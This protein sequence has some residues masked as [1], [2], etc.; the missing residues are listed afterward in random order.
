[1]DITHADALA[2]FVD[3]NS[4]VRRS[5]DL[6]RKDFRCPHADCTYGFSWTLEEPRDRDEWLWLRN[7]RN[8]EINK[9]LVTHIN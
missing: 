3:S 7:R 4:T 9:H 6:D 2:S 5:G 8:A 1:M